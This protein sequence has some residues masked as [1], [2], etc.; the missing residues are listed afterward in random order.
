MAPVPVAVPLDASHLPSTASSSDAVSLVSIANLKNVNRLPSDQVLTLGEA[1]G[2]TV[3]Y[4]DNGCGKS[5]YARVIKKACRS[6][7]AIPNIRPNAFAPKPPGPATGEI[8]FT[9]G[10]NPFIA[11]WADA[12][13]TDPRLANVFVF[14][15]TTAGNYLD[16]DGP[17]A[18]TPRGLDVLP[19][20]SKLC[21][22]VK[23]SIAV[24]RDKLVELNNTATKQWTF[25]PTT[26]IGMQMSTLT[27]QTDPATI[28]SLA[29]FG[30]ADTKRLDE[31]EAAL[32]ADAKLKARET[33]AAAE[34][35]R[36]FATLVKLRVEALADVQ[37][38][39]VE[40]LITDS[41]QAAKQARELATQA[42]SEGFLSATG[43][44]LW[45]SL[46]DSARAFSPAAY[47]AKEF[48][49]TEEDAR[50]LLCQEPLTEEARQRLAKFEQFVRDKTQ[51][52]ATDFSLQLAKRAKEI[53]D[54]KPLESALKQIDADL[55]RAPDELRAKVS[56]FVS[57]ADISLESLNLNLK[58][59][60]WTKPDSILASP[61]VDV[62]ALAK[63]LEQRAQTEED[64]D[65][66]VLRSEMENERKELVDRQL[67][68]KIKAEVLA[69]IDRLKRVAKL[70]ACAKDCSTNAITALN[71]DLS[72]KLINEAYRKQFNAEIGLIGLKTIR[73]ELVD[74]AGQK[75]TTKFGL[76]LVDSKDHR[77]RD[78]ASEGE[79]RCLALAAFLAELSLAS[80]ASALVF[81]DPV[82]SL[83]YG[84]CSRIGNR[85]AQ[86]AKRRQ[87]I[88]FTHNAVFMH[89]LES[90]A[91]EIGISPTFRHLE[92]DGF[93]PGHCRDGLP[94]DH[95]KPEQR[96]DRLEKL[97]RE[98]AKAWGPK[99]NDV[100]CGQMR[101]LYTELRATVE[102]IVERVIMSDIVFRF[103]SFINLKHLPNLAGIPE[104]E[105]D[106]VAR[107]FQKCCDVTAAH[108]PASEKQAVIPDPVEAAKDIGDAK[109]LL[110]AI[111]GRH[112]LK[113]KSGA[114]APVP[115][116]TPSPTSS[117]P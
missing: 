26:K 63:A 56:A 16:E 114:T 43:G 79:Q 28:E 62:T 69:Q 115:I 19:K 24:E 85:L 15:S 52:I 117:A 40:K 82:S 3:I 93:V 35:L 94:W 87:V 84:Y 1:P 80:H 71:A 98:L 4:G 6:R 11:A 91:Q 102:R 112:K 95:Q 17:T 8:K 75:G 83:D 105:C 34:R 101:H 61:E 46:W 73:V 107:L 42:F 97:Q 23:A 44:T 77:V 86:E 27:A 13:A 53:G 109:A 14:D 64:A 66:P 65:D 12:K 100:L 32:K 47:P 81:D 41:K 25:S 55:A 2:L 21:D 96:I 57:S 36:A 104:A 70:D 5:G 20:L 51:Q 37:I 72:G 39:A 45:K 54:L 59:S 110:A 76:R 89:D 88:V 49:L 48:P 103:R 10:V 18:F 106:E 60:A 78:V 116:A 90:A 29:T 38:S 68:S 30:E 7:G 22:Q 67:L 108:D 74:I 92:W 113:S 33:R 9:V 99:P 111:R 31:L 50:C 58:A